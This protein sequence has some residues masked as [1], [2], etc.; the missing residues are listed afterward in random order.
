MKN[1]SFRVQPEKGGWI[2]T[3][4]APVNDRSESGFGA[5]DFIMFM[6]I[7]GMMVTLARLCL[8]H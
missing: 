6:A 5:K 8:A 4:L 1:R 2:R 7:V 3:T